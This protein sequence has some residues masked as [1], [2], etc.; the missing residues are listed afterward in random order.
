MIISTGQEKE[1]TILK[2]ETRRLGRGVEVGG[3]FW[4]VLG[5]GHAG[6]SCCPPRAWCD[7]NWLGRPEK[8]VWPYLPHALQAPSTGNCFFC[9]K[10]YLLKNSHCQFNRSS[11]K[12]KSIHDSCKNSHI[13]ADRKWK[14]PFASLFPSSTTKSHFSEVN[15]TVF[16]FFCFL[17]AFGCYSWIFSSLMKFT[18]I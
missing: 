16:A 8:A 13:K 1:E 10:T 9:T 17:P 4:S 11:L 6:G 5:S 3:Q 18:G 2:K 7:E 14:F 15:T 12:C